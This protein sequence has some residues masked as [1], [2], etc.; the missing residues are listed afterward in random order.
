MNEKIKPIYNELRINLIVNYSISNLTFKIID[1]EFKELIEKRKKEEEEFI[2]NNEEIKSILHETLISFGLSTNEIDQSI[3][4]IKDD[5]TG[6]K[7]NNNMLLVNF[8]DEHLMQQISDLLEKFIPLYKNYNITIEE[9]FCKILN[10]AHEHFSFF[11]KNN[12]FSE[13]NSNGEIKII[14]NAN[15]SSQETKVTLDELP[16]YKIFPS[17]INFVYYDDNSK[18]IENNVLF[19]EVFMKKFSNTPEPFKTIKLNFIKENCEEQQSFKKQPEESFV[20]KRFIKL[21]TFF[22]NQDLIC[23][24]LI[25]SSKY[26]VPLLHITKQDIT[27]LIKNL[28]E[29]EKGLYSLSTKLEKELIAFTNSFFDRPKGIILDGPPRSGKTYSTGI[30]L[31]YLNLF[32]IYR[33]LVAG[34][35]MQSLQGQSEKMIDAITGRCDVLPWEICVLYIDEVDSLAPNRNSQNLSQSQNSILGQFLAIT[36]GNK[37]KF[38]LLMIATTNRLAA[39][40]PAFEQRY[41]IKIFL[42]VP[43]YEA[44]RHWIDNVVKEYINNTDKKEL[45]I[46]RDEVFP[47]KNQILNMTLNF[48]AQAVLKVLGNIITNIEHHFNDLKDIK[49]SSNFEKIEN[50]IYD[51]LRDTCKSNNIYLGKYLLPDLVKEMGNKFDQS[52]E[53]TEITDLINLFDEKKQNKITPTKRILIDLNEKKGKEVIQVEYKNHIELNNSDKIIIKDTLEFINLI[54]NFDNE[55]SE[56]ELNK[57]LGSNLNNQEIPDKRFLNNRN[58]LL[59]E[60]DKANKLIEKINSIYKEFRDKVPEIK[61]L[62]KDLSEDDSSNKILHI[63]DRMIECIVNSTSSR[64]KINCYGSILNFQ[65]EDILKILL[66]LAMKSNMDYILLVDMEYFKKKTIISDEKIAEEL[67]YLVEESKKYDK[68]MIIFDL[69]SICGLTYE[70]SQLKQELIYSSKISYK[71]DE[72]DGGFSYKYTHPTAFKIA[73]EHF[74]SSATG[75]NN[76]WFI[77]ISSHNK[78]TLDFKLKLDWPLNQSGAKFELEMEENLREKKCKFCKETFTEK[79]NKHGSC[80]RHLLDIFYID[81]EYQIKVEI[82]NFEKNKFIENLRA[83]LVN[84]EILEETYKFEIS[85]YL[86]KNQLPNHQE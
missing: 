30:I 22:G 46:L 68:S 4:I 77:A 39:M 15:F 18:K 42:G 53:F 74:L 28:R 79:T 72:S 24:K 20:N 17:N 86:E 84:K 73:L 59:N 3:N 52:F 37:K 71:A 56:D 83:R 41:D 16:V 32:Q 64:N 48:S 21:L 26:G 2:L 58:F 50:V 5:N 76:N 54:K 60:D 8:S 70:F 7:F 34:D 44:R 66:Y 67:N 55:Y 25:G 61:E 27:Y 81:Q 6:Q 23:Q 36:D 14:D 1:K 69:D 45:N 75:N 78:I 11:Y 13:I 47:F 12:Q 38:N 63:L 80:Y 9:I 40:D 49:I 85:K 31:K 62:V 43:N 51:S 19:S 82:F 35:F 10:K 57:L 65:K 33:P 29:N